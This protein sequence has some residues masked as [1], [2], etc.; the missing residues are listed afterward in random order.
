MSCGDQ[1]Y[2]VWGCGGHVGTPLPR[3]CGTWVDAHF[4]PN[5]NTMSDA[6]IDRIAR[7]VVELL[8]E[9]SE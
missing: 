1:Y 3:P 2:Q 8:K 5:K 7:R 9:K 4:V 6:D